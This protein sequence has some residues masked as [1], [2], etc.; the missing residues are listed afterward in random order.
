M[1]GLPCFAGLINFSLHCPGM[2]GQACTIYSMRC[3]R[4]YCLAV[5]RRT[6]MA[7]LTVMMSEMPR[8]PCRSTSSATLNASVTGKLASTAACSSDYSP[9]ARCSSL[10]CYAYPTC[11]A[12]AVIQQ[13]SHESGAP[14]ESQNVTLHLVDILWYVPKD[15][16]QLSKIHPASFFLH[17]CG[18]CGRTCNGQVSH[19]QED[20]HWESQS[21]CPLQL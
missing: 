2:I 7:L 10:Q 17:A 14:H 9:T 12:V 13:Q 8:T 1:H 4:R 3:T 21:A 16:Q 18:A 6:R 5:G 19:H 11:G 15:E 20:G